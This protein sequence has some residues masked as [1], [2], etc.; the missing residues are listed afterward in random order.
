MD[1][2]NTVIIT[3]LGGVAEVYYQPDYI[4][5]IKIEFDELESGIC[6]ICSEELEDE[7]CAICD[8]DWNNFDIDK[9]YGV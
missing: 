6:P 3:V 2:T 9:Y 4:D 7:Y 1:K 5:V 8:I